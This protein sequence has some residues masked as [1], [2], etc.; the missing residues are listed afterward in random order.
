M[1]NWIL[2]LQPGYPGAGVMPPA[3]NVYPGGVGMAPSPAAAYPPPPAG[4]FPSSQP[5]YSAP[6][7]A[8]LAYPAGQQP[9][10][11]TQPAGQFYDQCSVTLQ[12]CFATS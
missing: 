8:P 11:G 12:F 3:S 10:P 1:L 2:F 4:T 7:P 5:G 9:Y 6:A